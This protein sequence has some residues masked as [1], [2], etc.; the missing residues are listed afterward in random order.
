MSALGGSAAGA[1]TASSIASGTLFVSQSASCSDSAGL[2]SAAVPFCTISAAVNVVEP[3]Q[4]VMVEPGTY[5]ES[6]SITRSGTADAPITIQGVPTQAGSP[7]YVNPAGGAVG[8]GVTGAQHIVIKGF[9]PSGEWAAAFS[10]GSSSD[11]TLDS[12]VAIS[13]KEPGIHVTGASSGVA[14]TRTAVLAQYSAGVEV[15]GG[16]TGTVLASDQVTGLGANSVDISLHGPTSTDVV[17]NTLV[18]DCRSGID[19][20]SGSTGTTI[21]NNIVE[22]GSATNLETSPVVFSAC[23]TPATA[24]ALTVSADSTSGTSAD[25]NL[26]DPVSGGTPYTWAG[27]AYA[28]LPAF[29]SGTS[30]GA[31]DLAVN[32]QLDGG[33][34]GNAV[35]YRLATTSAAIDAAD[36]SAAGETATDSLGMPRTDDPSIANSGTGGYYDVGAA[37]Y[38]GPLASIGTATVTTGALTAKVSHTAPTFTWTTNGSDSRPVVYDFGDGK[39]QVASAAS[40]VTHDYTRTGTYKI[41]YRGFDINSNAHYVVGADYTPVAPD[42]VLDTRRAVGV[43]TTTPVAAKS[44]VVLKLPTLDGV[45]GADMSAVVANVTV[46]Q[47]TAA[48]VLTVYPDGS[49]LPTASNLNYAKGETVANLV[50][51]SVSDGVVRLHNGSSGTVHVIVDLE[52]FYG[53]GGYGYKSLTP[54]RVLDTRSGK[55]TSGAGALAA[56]GK[57]RLNLSG[58]LPSGATTAVLN[59]TATQATKSGFLTAFPDGQSVPTASNLNFTAGHTVPNLVV[60]PIVKGVADIYNG[61]GGSVQVVADLAGYYGTAASGATLAFVPNGPLRIADTRSDGT[62]AVKAHGTL[63]I[64]PIG[65]LYSTPLTAAVL[66]VTVTQPQTSGVLTVYPGGASLP[67]VSNLNFTKGETVPNLVSVGGSSAKGIKIYNGSGG[68]VQVV[69]DQE[70]YFVPAR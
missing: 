56:H 17:G 67:T 41:S 19:L 18:S 52:G 60:V 59:L 34:A 14:V 38:Q 68:T 35:A 23:T 29:Q 64:L 53:P 1:T 13:Y 69:V 4:T 54:S 16:S 47:P 6:V 33:S 58:V 12:D 2:G 24:T 32:P 62:G 40:G 43:T 61:S 3:G 63:T 25:H 57:L 28:D 65:S 45:S 42:R 50:T 31:H 55:G 46:T 44:D 11:I 48:G 9:Q 39:P 30:Q 27:M 66:N 51:T 37:E 5:N 26:I 15:D 8:F 20:E 7:V 36:A 49:S 10:I 70:G 21:E 22:N